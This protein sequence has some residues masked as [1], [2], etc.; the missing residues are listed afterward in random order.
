MAGTS[1]FAV[2]KWLGAGASAGTIAVA[3][4]TAV[5]KT[6][7]VGTAIVVGLSAYSF[8]FGDKASGVHEY[9]K[10]ASELLEA[11][12]PGEALSYMDA[13]EDALDARIAAATRDIEDQEAN[14]VDAGR[15]GTPDGR[16]HRELTT[17]QVQRDV[18]S[19][20][21]TNVKRRTGEITSQQWEQDVS[22]GLR[23]N[24]ERSG[25]TARHFLDTVGRQFDSDVAW[26]LIRKDLPAGA[27]G[28]L[29]LWLTGHRAPDRA[30]SVQEYARFYEEVLAYASDTAAGPRILTEYI[31]A[32]D[33]SVRNVEREAS[34]EKAEDVLN[35]FGTLFED[36]EIG[37]VAMTLRLGAIPPGR[38]RDA[39]LIAAAEKAPGSATARSLLPTY[40]RLLVRRGDFM[41]A[42]V[43][44]DTEGRL[45]SISSEREY[46]GALIDLADRCCGLSPTPIPNRWGRAKPEPADH[47]EP[48]PGLTPL[49]I[50]VGLARQLRDAGND[51]ASVEVS[52]A[53]LSKAQTVP[54]NLATGGPLH[55]A[56][57]ICDVADPGTA[58]SLAHY[59]LALGQHAL[60]NTHTGDA[61]VEKLTSSP[62]PSKDLQPYVLHLAAQK[63]ATAKDYDLAVQRV[64]EAMKLLPGSPVLSSF[65]GTVDKARQEKA[66]QDRI[67]QAMREH[68]AA[69]EASQSPG[70][71][72]KQYSKAAELHIT[73]KEFEQAVGLYE[74]IAERWPDH[75]S[76]VVVLSRA[77]RLLDEAGET[78]AAEHLGRMTQVLMNAFQSAEGSKTENV[79][80]DETSR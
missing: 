65:R 26:A 41:K 53:A 80:E 5:V 52:F 10:L 62:L 76:V 11:D 67:R 12:K 15:D 24:A 9:A 73:L 39:A 28:E 50:S 25:R 59:L 72:I 68:M 43:A 8:S 49:S 60:R 6:A 57:D 64:D 22:A 33:A 79:R 47:V 34:R 18:V 31:A 66:R 14:V 63:A 16:P 42:M 37:A 58:K 40:A 78:K 55:A 21:R 46:A 2:I 32:L 70:E 51:S 27:R 54:L 38:E 44:L 19:L 1:V 75:K 74:R 17:W 56:S 29:A 20:L 36:S 48:V 23:A 77:S 45:G 61:I 30:A 71:A 35:T 7:A 4:T 3:T 69:A 13:L